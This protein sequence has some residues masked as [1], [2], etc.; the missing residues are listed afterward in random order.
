MVMA[1]SLLT[2]KGQTTIPKKIREYLNLHPGDKIDFIVD[3]NGKSRTRTI[4]LRY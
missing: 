3:E 4:L 2:V 1:T